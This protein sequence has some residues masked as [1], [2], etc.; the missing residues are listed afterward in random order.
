MR[1][2]TTWKTSRFNGEQATIINR[3]HLDV[4]SYTFVQQRLLSHG[5]DPLYQLPM[6]N[7]CRSVGQRRRGQLISNTSTLGSCQL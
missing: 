5:S 4:Q 3:H 1:A 7:L 6:M 2:T